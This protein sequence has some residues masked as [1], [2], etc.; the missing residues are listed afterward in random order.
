MKEIGNIKSVHTM[1]LELRFNSGKLN[2]DWDQWSCLMT[3]EIWWKFGDIGLEFIPT[4]KSF[5]PRKP[6][7]QAIKLYIWP[8]SLHKVK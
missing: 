2:S 3:E 6:L 7:P 1:S 8:H 5:L 4:P